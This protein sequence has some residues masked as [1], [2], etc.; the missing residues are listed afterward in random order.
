MI[1]ARG[2]DVFLYDETEKQFL[3]YSGTAWAASTSVIL[4]TTDKTLKVTG[5][6]QKNLIVNVQKSEFN[7][8]LYSVAGS[9]STVEVT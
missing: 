4:D 8:L 7:T 2:N 9:T 1:S 5:L 6:K 3:A